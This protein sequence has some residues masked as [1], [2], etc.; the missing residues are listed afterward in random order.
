[1]NLNRVNLS[2]TDEPDVL[3]QLERNSRFEQTPRGKAFVVQYDGRILEFHPGEALPLDADIANVLL[4]REWVIV[5]DDLKGMQRPVFREISRYNI[6][7]GV[8]MRVSKT[9]CRFCGKECGNPGSLGQHIL[10][11]CPELKDKKE[12]EADGNE[13][14][15]LV[16]ADTE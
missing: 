1:M 5:G 7:E 2:L 10:R 11:F 15:E 6:A 9:T 13:V 4:R 12:T 16:S 14:P 3:H 8:E